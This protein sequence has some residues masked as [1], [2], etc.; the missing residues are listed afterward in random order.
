MKFFLEED[1][2]GE[3]GEKTIIKVK[4]V[5]DKDEA[6]KLKKIDKS[7]LHKCYHDEGHG[8]PCTREVL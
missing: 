7:Y 2:I 8:R 6:L 3:N 1:A 4:E 5:K